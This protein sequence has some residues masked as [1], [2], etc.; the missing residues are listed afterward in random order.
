MKVKEL[1][2]KLQSMD[3]EEPV[4]KSGYEGGMVDVT[5]VGYCH[6]ELN[7]NSEWWQGPHE[8]IYEDHPK[9]VRAVFIS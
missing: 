4:I 5:N 9:G 2:E 8:L 7:V 3:P 1:I 6:I